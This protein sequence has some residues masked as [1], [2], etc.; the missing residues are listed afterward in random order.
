MPETRLVAPA[1]ARKLC[2]GISESTIR[3]LVAQGAFPKPITL[4]RNRRG[5]AAR[6][7]WV[8]D[9]LVT[10]VRDRIAADRGAAA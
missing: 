4:S 5:Q 3:R 6:I 1:E 2:G 7:A 10:W 8:Y 9:E